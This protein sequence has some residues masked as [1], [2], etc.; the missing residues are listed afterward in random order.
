MPLKAG[1]SR[2]RENRRITGTKVNVETAV[3]V[4]IA[5][6]YMAQIKKAPR[7][8]APFSY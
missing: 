7:C 4:P 2:L 1:L 3:K 5:P 8:G 6:Q